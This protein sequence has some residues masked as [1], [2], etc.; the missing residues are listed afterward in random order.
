MTD[1]PGLPK[2]F[3]LRN[4]RKSRRLSLL[5]VAIMAG[6]DIGNLSRIERQRQIPKPHCARKLADFYGVTMDD[7]YRPILDVI[8]APER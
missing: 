4:A 7:I 8:P 5:E 3:D 1:I 2:N 6:I